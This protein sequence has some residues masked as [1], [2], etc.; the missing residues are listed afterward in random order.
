ME[1]TYYRGDIFYADLT[2]KNSIGSEQVG[3]RPVVILQNN[4]GNKY[5]P[6]V[7]IAPITSKT[8]VKNKIPTHVLLKKKKSRLIKDSIILIEQIRVIDKKRLKFYSGKLE[9]NEINKVNEAI[10]I[11]LGL[12]NIKED[13][14]ENQIASYGVLANIYLNH[15]ANST[16]TNKL[17]RNYILTLIEI[18]EPEQAEKII[19]KY[20]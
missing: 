9:K 12:N 4:I 17:L 13:I 11:A 3:I 19:E 2:E 5:S 14:T 18:I 20:L 1:E 8:L 6:T 15:S 16:I 10:R 7:I